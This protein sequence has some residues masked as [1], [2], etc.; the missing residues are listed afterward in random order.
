M[1]TAKNG[2]G[3]KSMKT[4]R[5]LTLLAVLLLAFCLAAPAASADAAVVR[6]SNAQELLAAIAP[7]T[8]IELE[9]GPA[10]R[11]HL[12]ALREL[13]GGRRGRRARSGQPDPPRP[14]GRRDRGRAP[15]GRRAA[16]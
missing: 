13:L 7:D 9:P 8:V 1:N 6:V 15:R 11:E 16:L 5:I 2:K 4:S 3:K 10:A 12:A 14:R